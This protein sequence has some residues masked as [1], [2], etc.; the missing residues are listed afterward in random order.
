MAMVPSGPFL[1]ALMV[2]GLIAGYFL[3][4][5]QMERE[6]AKLKLMSEGVGIQPDL[7]DAGPKPESPG[8]KPKPVLAP[9]K[10]VAPPKAEPIVA[11]DDGI[12]PEI[13]AM[14]GAAVA[15]FVGAG[16]RIR[17]T[18]LLSV[19]EGLNAWAQQGRVIIQASH[20]LGMR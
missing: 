7:P 19:P 9:P 16:A 6:V 4:R 17:S 5:W 18:R 11:K 2:A 14:I 3:L 20:N 8:S 10:A 13:L 15:Q 1:L 12:T